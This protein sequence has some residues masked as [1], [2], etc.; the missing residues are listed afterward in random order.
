VLCCSLLSFFTVGVNKIFKK[1][2]IELAEFFFTRDLRFMCCFRFKL[3]WMTQRMGTSGRDVPLETQFML[4]ESRD[5]GGGGEAV[6]V[7]MLPLLEGQFR[8]ALQGNDRDELEICIES[9]KPYCPNPV[10]LLLAH[11][12]VSSSPSP[13]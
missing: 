6:Y 9:G 2:L 7:V 10:L 8:A 13:F 1:K 12:T 11:E 4:L 5:G 3:W